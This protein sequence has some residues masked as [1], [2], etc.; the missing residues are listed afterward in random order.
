MAREGITEP[1]I[2]KTK[3]LRLHRIM[4]QIAEMHREF[5]RS[6]KDLPCIFSITQH[7]CM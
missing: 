4:Y 6:A 1:Q 7:M 2:R 5:Q 3:Q